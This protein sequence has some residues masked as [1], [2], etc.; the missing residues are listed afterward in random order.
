MKTWVAV[1]VVIVAITFSGLVGYFSG[2]GSTIPETRTTTV[3]TTATTTLS[4][5]ATENL[6]NSNDEFAISSLRL[7]FG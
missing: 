4:T 3:Y 6:L 5:S 7:L 2:I 1:T